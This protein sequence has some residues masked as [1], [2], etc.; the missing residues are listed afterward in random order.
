M[1]GCAH[2][3]LQRGAAGLNGRQRVVACGREVAGRQPLVGPNARGGIVVFEVDRVLRRQAGAQAGQGARS[4]QDL[5]KRGGPPARLTG[6]KRQERPH[7]R[8]KRTGIL[9]F[10]QDCEGLTLQL[11]CHGRGGGMA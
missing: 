11:E 10:R 2:R 4:A 9:Q 6:V 8:R 5:L 7:P 1:G 3:R